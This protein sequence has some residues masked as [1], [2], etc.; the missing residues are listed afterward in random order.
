L[1][2][3][4]LDP[5]TAAFIE[6]RSAG[7]KFRRPFL[8]LFLAIATAVLLAACGGDDDGNDGNGSGDYGQQAQEVFDSLAGDLSELSDEL[9]QA[10]SG[11]DLATGLR[12][13]SAD[14]NAAAAELE[15]LDPP[16]D[17]QQVNDDLIT[18]IQGFASDLDSTADDVESGGRQ[19]LQ[20]ASLAL[21]QAA[22]EFQNELNEI[23]Q[24]AVEAGVAIE[25]TTPP[26]EETAPPETTPAE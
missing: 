7:M 2:F 21:V 20:T 8:A 14:I 15:A 16:E 9:R 17:A 23:R 6:V 24:R 25:P 5:K 4:P 1:D 10:D 3:T 26:S 22:L 18:T 11:E 13:A 12:Q 19:Q